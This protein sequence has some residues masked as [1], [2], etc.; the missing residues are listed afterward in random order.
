MEFDLAQLLGRRRE[1]ANAAK[2]PHPMLIDGTF[3][4]RSRLMLMYK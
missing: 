2:T 4:R 1:T 3:Q